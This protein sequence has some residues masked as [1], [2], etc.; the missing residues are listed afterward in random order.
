MLL[1]GG[2]PLNYVP[3][4]ILVDSKCKKPTFLLQVP[5]NSRNAFCFCP[6]VNISLNLDEA[7]E[8]SSD[9]AVCK[10]VPRLQRYLF[11]SLGGEVL[12]EGNIFPLFL[13]RWVDT[14]CATIK[15][16]MGA[17]LLNERLGWS[18]STR[19]QY[20]ACLSNALVSYKCC[21]KAL[22]L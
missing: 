4:T 3:G 17:G 16:C 10:K 8:K 2:G 12:R 18:S 13:R 15:F 21:T 9:N 14:H 19:W 20:S 22:F 5:A 11:S 1:L 6:A 7:L